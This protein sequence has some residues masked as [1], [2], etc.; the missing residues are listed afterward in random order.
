MSE[1]VEMMM[2]IFLPCPSQIECS[3]VN[4]S[5]VNINLVD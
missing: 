3:A 2:G 4:R 1:V 5:L